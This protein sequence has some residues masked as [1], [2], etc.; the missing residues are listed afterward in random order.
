MSLLKKV[1]KVVPERDTQIMVFQ[2]YSATLP[3]ETTARWRSVVEAWE[4]DSTQ[5]N[6]FRL[7]RPVVTEAAIKRQLNAADTLEL[8]EGRA[9]VLHDKLSASGVVIMG[10]EI[11]EQQ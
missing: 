5:P 6:P 7:K 3:D 10:L 1:K 4:A 11:E 8:K 9:V 2:E